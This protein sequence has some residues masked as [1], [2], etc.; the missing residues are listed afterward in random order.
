MLNP[1]TMPPVDGC[2]RH[3]V[4]MSHIYR[5]PV[6]VLF[7][8][9]EYV[10]AQNEPSAQRKSTIAGFTQEIADL[11]IMLA[12]PAFTTPPVANSA[13]EVRVYDRIRPGV[14]GRTY[15]DYRIT[16]VQTDIAPDCYQLTLSIRNR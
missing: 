8:S 14:P 2:I 15:K 6:D 11:E 9:V 12:L 1:A 3:G 13:D 7:R 16:N 4:F 5:R 10:A